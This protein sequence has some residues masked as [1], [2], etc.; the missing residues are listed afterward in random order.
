MY[1]HFIFNNVRYSLIKVKDILNIYSIPKYS[2]KFL[3]N[4]LNELN[5]KMIFKFQ[6]I[7]PLY[8]V[9]FQDQR[10]IIDGLQRLE[11][12]KNNNLFQESVIPIVDILAEDYN[13]INTYFNLINENNKI[14]ENNE[15]NDIIMEEI[16]E[17][18]EK[19]INTTYKYFINN[20]PNSFKFNGK[21]RPYLDNNKFIEIL[22]NIYSKYNIECEKVFIQK[23]LDL[24]NKYK[25]QKIEWFPAK[26]K[27]LNETLIDIIENENCLYFGMIP[28]QWHLHLDKIPKYMSEDKISQSLRQQVWTKYANN[29]LEIKCICCNLN[30]I[31]AFTFES[32]HIIARSKGGECNINNLVPIC[33]LCN[34][35]MGNINMKEFIANHN[36]KLH[37]LLKMN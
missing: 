5:N 31:N 36:Y 21:R 9:L 29:K 34:K 11:I 16:D 13:D 26:S 12:Y 23:L 7:T 28:D 14:I 27:V 25:K 20:Y 8:F 35:S 30:T 2:K 10:Y 3:K 24:N 6:P 22:Q 33:G 19:I 17:Q 1:N 32:G 18:K 4:N 15:I 37:N